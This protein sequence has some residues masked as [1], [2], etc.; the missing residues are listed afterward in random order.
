MQTKL[1]PDVGGNRESLATRT[2]VIA[3]NHYFDFI[4]SFTSCTMNAKSVC[5]SQISLMGSSA[6][7]ERTKECPMGPS[8]WGLAPKIP[9]LKGP[10]KEKRHRKRLQLCPSLP[11]LPSLL[12]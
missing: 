10:P 3:E 6:W 4:K 11:S 5:L 8:T 12:L 7:E 9:P 2:S 1:N